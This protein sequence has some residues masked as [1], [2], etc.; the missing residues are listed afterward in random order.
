MHKG[1]YADDCIVS[2]VMQ[3]RCYIVA[4][5]D[6]ALRRRIRKIPGI[7][8]YN[9]FDFRRTNHVCGTRAIQGR[10]VA[11]RVGVELVNEKTLIDHRMST[12]SKPYYEICLLILS[13]QLIP[14]ILGT[15]RP[16]CVGTPLMRWNALRFYI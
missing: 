13:V 4:T 6:Q 15:L 2:R 7:T 16:N 9:L 10:K 3:H 12:L 8:L 11:N 5:N 1:T 14:P